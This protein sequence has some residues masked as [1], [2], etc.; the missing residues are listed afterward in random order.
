[1]SIGVD[2]KH[3]AAVQSF[4]PVTSGT[5]F[6]SIHQTN[7]LITNRQGVFVIVSAKNQLSAI[8]LQ[9]FIKKTVVIRIG[10]NAVGIFAKSFFWTT[11]KESS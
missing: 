5:G 9:D 1:M 4:I 3:G 6:E 8:I 11:P 2:A 10:A 7:A